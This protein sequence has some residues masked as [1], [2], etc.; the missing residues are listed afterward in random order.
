MKRLIAL[1]C[2]LAAP[3]FAQVQPI[4][5]PNHLLDDA[6]RAKVLTVLMANY[7]ATKVHIVVWLPTLAKDDVLL[8][9]AVQYFKTKGI[10]Q[11]GEDNGV[12]VLIDWANH[13]SR[14]E[15]GYGL[16]GVMTDARTKSTQDSVMNPHFKKGDLAGGLLA[17]I[18][19]LSGYSKEWLTDK[20]KPP[21]AAA[22]AS[23]L[24]WSATAMVIVVFGIGLIII[25]QVKR[26]E[27]EAAE[28]AVADAARL[29]RARQ[30][31]EDINASVRMPHSP[32]YAAGLGASAAAASYRQ[33]AR[34]TPRPSSR[35]TP[36]VASQP[37]GYSSSPPPPPP[38]P[39]PSSYD[40]GGGSSGGGGSD[41]SW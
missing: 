26:R 33:P 36:Y 19:I 3:A 37:S 32:F 4:D 12:L 21:V 35:S 38:P 8:D 23:N 40:S 41:S 1:L 20:D 18:G 6:A 31:R 16:E 15:V 2:L 39:P 24:V 14:I 30:Q 25:L 34:S 28:E 7:D 11:K 22:H 9:K 13:R 29:R 10:G 17:G 5:D 27:R